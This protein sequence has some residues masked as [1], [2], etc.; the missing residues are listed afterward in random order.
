MSKMDI[1]H[2]AGI[3]I[4]LKI[5]SVLNSGINSSYKTDFRHI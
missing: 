4:H 2:A 1:H 3:A 5:D